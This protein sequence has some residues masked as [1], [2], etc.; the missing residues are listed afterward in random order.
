[1]KRVILFP[2]L[3]FTLFVNITYSQDIKPNKYGLV[4][5]SNL[6]DYKTIVNKD[7]SQ[8]LINLKEFIPAITLDIRYADSNNFVGEP[9]YK[10]KKAFARYPAAIALKAVQEE[11]SKKGLG[12]LIF[13]GYRPYSVTVKFFEKTQDTIFCA[14]PWR[15]SRH[16]RGCA[17]DLSLVY[18]NTGKELEMPTPFDDFSKKAHA[19]CTDLPKNVIENRELLKDVM[20]RH[21][22]KVLVDEWWHYDFLDWK[23]FGLMDIPFEEL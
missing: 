18:L 16:N 1:M 23:K 5:V 8:A 15:G 17:I 10:L 6:Q 13:D 14:V 12:L 21:G 4:I 11:L 9:V 20:T 7:S 3:A 19:E 2:I 22:F